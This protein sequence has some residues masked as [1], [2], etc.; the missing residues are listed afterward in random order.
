MDYVTAGSTGVQVSP[1]CLGTMSFGDEADEDVS[2]QM[3]HRARKAGINFFDTADVYGQ[4]AAEE[5]L[6]KLVSGRRDEAVI[7]SKVF[8]PTGQDVNARGLSRRHIARAVEASLA[9]LGTEWIDFYFVHA[10]DELTPIEETLGALDDL[11]RQGKI[12]YPAVSNWAAWQIAMALGISAREHLARFE[13][14]EPMYNLVRRQAEVEILPLAEAQKMGVVT[15]SPLGGGLLTGKYGTGKRP[16][17]GRLVEN[18]R[19]ADRYGLQTDYATADRFTAF[20]QEI[21]VTPPTLAVAWAMAH[22]AVTAPIIGARNLA[23]LEDSLAALN[24]EMT[25]ELREKISALS[26]APAPATDRT[27]TLKPNWT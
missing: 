1:L 21:G 2:A 23:Q 16:E 5:I 17:S 9:R 10:F 14:I 18:A 6:G 20:A 13:L 12:R 19:Y 4:G 15:Y 25:G 11:Q 27:E 26:P 24:V 8:F 22:P 3:F 7:A